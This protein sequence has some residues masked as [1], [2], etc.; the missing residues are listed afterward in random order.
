MPDKHGIIFKEHIYSPDVVYATFA[1]KLV[2]GF[3]KKKSSVVL[4]K[5]IASKKESTPNYSD[6]ELVEF[7]SDQKV[8]VIVELFKDGKLLYSDTG[9]NQIII[10]NIILEGYPYVPAESENKKIKG[11][12]NT[13]LNY[14]GNLQPLPAQIPEPFL[15]I[16]RL[17][18]DETPIF[19]MVRLNIYIE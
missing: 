2:H 18:K 6:L 3:K 9:F 16:F 19:F 12:M 10:K 5:K 14:L 11:G 13:Q 15:L 17:E 1:L 8:K 7:M 4:D